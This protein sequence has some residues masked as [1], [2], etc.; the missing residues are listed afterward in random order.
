MPKQQKWYYMD[1]PSRRGPVTAEQARELYESGKIAGRT[2]VYD[3]S[4]AEWV[5]AET[6]DVFRPQPLTL[7][8]PPRIRAA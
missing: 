5:E 3:S 4:V 7:P 8:V 2:L 1:G 6:L